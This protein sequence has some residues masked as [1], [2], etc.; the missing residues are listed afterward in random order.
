MT[1]KPIELSLS[2]KYVQ[3]WGFWEATREL[4]QNAIDNERDMDVAYAGDCEDLIIT[5]RNTTIPKTS[6]LMGESTKTGDSKTIGEFGEG[7]KLA[8]LVLTRMGFAVTVQNGPDIWTPVFEY[9]DNWNQDVLKIRVTEAAEVS[10]DLVFRIHCVP[11]EQYDLLAT[12]Y[13]PNVR[14]NLILKDRA[15]AGNIYIN[16]LF[17]SHMPKFLFGY[18]F[19]PS[20]LKVDRDRK[21]VEQ[22]RVAWETSELWANDGDP[23]ELW[24]LIEQK[25]P[26]VSNVTTYMS[27]NLKAFEEIANKWV[28]QNGENACPVVS[29]SD[30]EKAEASGLRPVV[31]SETML[32]I[33]TKFK[34][35]KLK[36]IKSEIQKDVEALGY[37]IHL[38][39]EDAREHWSHLKSE[40]RQRGLLTHS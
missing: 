10:A 19:K 27:H 33:V 8:L 24:R 1:V 40:L 14:G 34:K 32:D 15:I 29:S 18:N 7:Y 23:T 31:T 22:F 25:S 16:G 13:L 26:E 2:P 11:Q 9:S 3:H 30:A 21:K 38:L 35:F 6:L 37:H 12:R 36:S 4:L 5:S 20:T 39:P 17:I 28:E